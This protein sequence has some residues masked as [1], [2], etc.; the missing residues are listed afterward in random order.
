ML[1]IF[2]IQNIDFY[3]KQGFLPQNR[4]ICNMSDDKKVDAVQ[5]VLLVITRG[6]LFSIK[7]FLRLRFS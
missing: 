7:Y 3:L 5:N 6:I 4:I 1:K 2:N